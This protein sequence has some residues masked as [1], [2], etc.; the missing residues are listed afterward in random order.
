MKEKRFFLTSLKQICNEYLIKF[1]ENQSAPK[2]ENRKTS[3]YSSCAPNLLHVLV[4]RI[5]GYHNLCSPVSHPFPRM[6]ASDSHSRIMAPCNDRKRAII[7]GCL[8]VRPGRLEV[9]CAAIMC[10]MVPPTVPASN[11]NINLAI[12]WCQSNSVNS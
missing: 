2:F 1:S 6:N 5:L 12:P 11:Q 4:S 9:S 10:Y 8:E 3:R 7:A